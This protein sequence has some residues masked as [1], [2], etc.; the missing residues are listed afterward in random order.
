MIWKKRYAK[1][2]NGKNC[3]GCDMKEV[4]FMEIG[5]HFNFKTRIYGSVF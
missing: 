4:D 1:K 5:S 2:I 3:K